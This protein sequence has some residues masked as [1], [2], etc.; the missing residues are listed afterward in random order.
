MQ[1]VYDMVRDALVERKERA[2]IWLNADLE[3]RH[4]SDFTSPTATGIHE[5]IAADFILLTGEEVTHL[6][7]V[8]LIAITKHADDLGVRLEAAAVAFRTVDVLP[9]H[10]ET[11]DGGIRYEVSRYNMLRKA[12][13]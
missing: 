5:D 2:L 11:I 1:T 10:A 9:A 12:R 13:L 7:A 8:N 4:L 6:D 3:A